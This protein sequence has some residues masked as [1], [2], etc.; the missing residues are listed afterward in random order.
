MIN[1]K[2][3]LDKNYHCHTYRCNHATSTSEEMILKAINEGYKELGI[4]EHVCYK[5]KK[6]DD[7]WRL[8]YNELNDYLEEISE[9]KLKYK[10]KI[11]IFCGFESEWIE[12]E[13]E[14]LISLFN[15]PKVDYFIFGNHFIDKIDEEDYVG[16][17]CT[18]KIQL[19]RYVDNI[20]RGLKS[21]IFSF[22][23][24]PDLFMKA[25]TN[26]DIHTENASI[27]LIKLAIKYDCPLEINGV[28]IMSGKRKIGN[29]YRFIYPHDNFW[30]LVEK[31]K[32]KVIISNDAHSKNGLSQDL[33]KL[34]IEYA[35]KFNLN[36]INNLEIKK[37]INK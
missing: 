3:Y 8:K 25:Y 31:Y 19:N 13:K 36:I 5:N 27:R 4:S 10:D 37:N 24:H 20:E 1:K 12:S 14:W 2:I 17:I 15:N 32:A 18:N 6:Q 34:L 30:K 11:K 28:G 16:R 33:G 23:T 29:E 22:I 7:T 35:S 9:L 21:G 26:W